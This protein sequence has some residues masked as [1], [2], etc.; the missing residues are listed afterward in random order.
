MCQQP[1]SQPTGI[2]NLCL[3]HL[4]IN[5]NTLGGKLHT[6][7]CLRIDVELVLCVSRK[8]VGLSNSRITYQNNYLVMCL[9]LLPL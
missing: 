2:P 5:G 4:P 3:Y 9:T 6:D 7:G 8:D 1:F